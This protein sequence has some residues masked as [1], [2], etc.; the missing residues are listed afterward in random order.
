M[1]SLRIVTPYG[2]YKETETSIINVV[3]TGGQIGIL[4][5]HMPMVAMLEISKLTTEEQSG[6]ETYA[7]SGGMIYFDRDKATIVAPSVENVKDIDIARAQKAKE[8]AEERLSSPREDT[9]I[10]RAELALKRAM[11]RI[12]TAG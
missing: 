7:L 6:R 9:D 4:P 5:S 1:I 11:N 12:N 3:T 8:R 10:Q 2:L